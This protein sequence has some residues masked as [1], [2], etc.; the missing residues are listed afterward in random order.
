MV[1]AKGRHCFII[2]YVEGWTL[3]DGLNGR[4]P[5]L[6]DEASALLDELLN[7]LE[8]LHS[9]SIFHGDITPDHVL[10]QRRNGEWRLLNFASLRD[11]IYLTPGGQN[12]SSALAP[13]Y[14]PPYAPEERWR[15]KLCPASDIYTAG[16]TTLCLVTGQAPN[17]L[18]DLYYDR[19][20]KTWD[21]DMVPVKESFKRVLDHMLRYLPSDRFQ[22]VAELKAA[23]LKSRE[24]HP[25]P[26]SACAGRLSETE[27]HC[28]DCGVEFERGWIE[29]WL[30]ETAQPAL[31]RDVVEALGQKTH[32]FA[33][34]EQIGLPV[35][36]LEEAWGN[37]IRLRTG[38]SEPDLRMWVTEEVL[39]ILQSNLVIQTKRINWAKRE[40]L[41]QAALSLG[42]PAE[43]ARTILDRECAKRGVEIKGRVLYCP[44]PGC[45]CCFAHKDLQ[46]CPESAALLVEPSLTL[47]LDKFVRPRLANN[48]WETPQDKQALLARATEMGL[49]EAEAD[50]VLARER[51]TVEL[52]DRTT[53]SVRSTPIGLGIGGTES[54]PEEERGQVWQVLS[55]TAH[56]QRSGK[57]IVMGAIALL[58][59]IGG[60][61]A[62]I[63]RSRSA[64]HSPVVT[65][66]DASSTSIQAGQPVTFT[67]N[68]TDPDGDQL[69]YEWASS[70]GQIVGDGRQATL[71]TSDMYGTTGSV[72]VTVSLRM[73]D[74][75]GGIT[76]GQK[77]ITVKSPGTPEPPPAAQ[78]SPPV[79]R[80]QGSRVEPPPGPT[81]QERALKYLNQAQVLFEQRLYDAAIRECERGLK[82]DPENQA[83]RDR[84]AAIEKVK[85]ILNEPS[86]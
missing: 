17:E 22:N 52:A 59:V 23:L 2:E 4:P 40:S 27:I 83:L 35:T 64:N 29:R 16:L 50:R 45:G 75:R 43:R 41:V 31:D 72:L 32:L 3:A 78:L 24:L 7:V 38:T 55:R 70:A 80:A 42:L 39:P 68:G 18:Y 79:D 46:N 48:L 47:W 85:D 67:V 11:A 61:V 74:Q 13:E 15:G 58:L 53:V 21:L 81:R 63:F 66:F 51:D 9:H 76:S 37:A 1:L 36:R 30:S 57:A 62:L 12:G 60:I 19:Q 84:K 77:V 33:P 69:I 49:S 28:P 25:C 56:L 5:F 82:L 54:K 8:E 73:T 44:V 34:L 14:I 6:E 10:R 65:A 86:H 71:D 20:S 26:N